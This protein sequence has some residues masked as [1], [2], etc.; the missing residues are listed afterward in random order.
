MDEFNELSLC[1]EEVM[2]D[3]ERY[4]YHF[5]EEMESEKQTFSQRTTPSLSAAVK[6]SELWVSDP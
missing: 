3:V 1:F 6:G 2:H 5:F 4:D